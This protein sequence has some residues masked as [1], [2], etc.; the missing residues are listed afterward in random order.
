M[1][2]TKLI[3]TKS[4]YYNLTQPY[5]FFQEGKTYEA[6]CN[7]IDREYANTHLTNSECNDCIDSRNEYIYSF[8]FCDFVIGSENAKRN[9]QNIGDWRNDQLRKLNI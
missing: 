4:F 9:F 2:S 5:F 1:K 8:T 3:C 6:I 7:E